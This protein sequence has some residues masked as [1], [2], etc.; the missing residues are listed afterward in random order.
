MRLHFPMI[1]ISSILINE[2]PVLSRNGRMQEE[3]GK[4]PVPVLLMET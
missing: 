1:L 2:L 4:T 3:S